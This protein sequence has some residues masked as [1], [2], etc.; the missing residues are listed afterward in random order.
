MPHVVVANALPLREAIPR[1]APIRVTVGGVIVKIEQAFLEREGRSALLPAMTI[2]GPLR[3]R[4]L[5]LASERDDGV[6]LR[7]EPMTDP[8]KTPAV[9][10]AIACAAEWLRRL[11]PDARHAATNIAPALAQL[12]GVSLG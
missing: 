1:F 3:Q 5:L 10:L 8:E 9:H 11:S 12:D 4:F 2:A 7:L 6:V